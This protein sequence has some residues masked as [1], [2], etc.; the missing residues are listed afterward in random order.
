M[1]WNMKIKSVLS[2]FSLLK[3]SITSDLKRK[4][5]IKLFIQSAFASGSRLMGITRIHLM[6]CFL[7]V[8][9][10]C[11]LFRLSYQGNLI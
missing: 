9:E 7:H 2:I 6:A 10:E 5:V 4:I 8:H 3:S 11:M 1:M